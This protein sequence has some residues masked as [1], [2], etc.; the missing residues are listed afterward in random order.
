M[1]VKWFVVG[2]A[3]IAVQSTITTASSKRG[4]KKEDEPKENSISYGVF[5]GESMSSKIYNSMLH[6]AT[7]PVFLVMGIAS[8]ISAV[9]HKSEAEG[10]HGRGKREAPSNRWTENILKVLG[11]VQK[12][13]EKYQHLEGEIINDLDESIQREFNG[14]ESL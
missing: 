14:K 10:M 13:I 11:N 2:F 1:H 6:D 5:S 7:L 8:A 4:K 9:A 3:V 12:A